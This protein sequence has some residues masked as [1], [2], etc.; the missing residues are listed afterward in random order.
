[1]NGEAESSSETLV[2]H[3]ATQS[4]NSQISLTSFHNVDNF[5]LLTVTQLTTANVRYFAMNTQGLLL[6]LSSKAVGPSYP[7][8]KHNERYKYCAFYYVNIYTHFLK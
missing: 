2:T 6:T 4:R 1:M 5:R 7:R 3:L 8:Y